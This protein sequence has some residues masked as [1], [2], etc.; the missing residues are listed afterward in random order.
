MKIARREFLY[1]AAGAAVLPGLAV[2]LSALPQPAPNA[3]N[4]AEPTASERS[5]MSSLARAFMEQ[6]DVPGLSVAVGRA[7]TLVYEDA[8][9]FADR[10]KRE[11][12]SPMHLFRIASV[13]KPITSVA[14]F[15]LIE[16][17][18]IRLTD[19]IFGPDAI[20]GSD[21]EMP[22]YR[23]DRPRVDDI[24]VEHLLTHTAG[25]WRNSAD[26]PMFMNL[27]MNHSQLIQWT[28]RNRPL[29]HSPGQNFAY[30]NFGY[31]VLGRV[32]EKVTGQPYAA[33][34]RNS[35]LKR[36]GVNDMTIAGNTLAQRLPEEV[37]YYGQGTDNP[38]GM[39]AARLDSCGGWIA[40]PADLVQFLMHVSGFATPP[41]ILK[42][43]TIAIMTTPSDVNDFYA[44]GWFVN[45]ANNWS[46]G[47]SLPG[48]TTTAARTHSGFC[49]AA[50][51]NTR[52]LNSPLQAG[53]DRLVWNMVGEVKSWQVNDETKVVPGGIFAC[54][55]EPDLKSEDAS[56]PTPIMFTNRTPHNVSLFWL[57]YR[58]ERVAY[59]TL[60]SGEAYTQETYIS[61]PWVIVDSHGACLQIVLPGNTTRTVAIE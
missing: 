48:T 12:V 39:N 43:Q 56:F 37:K 36:C 61:H 14:I 8:F 21:Y 50:F 38:Y 51:A 3:D 2:P 13:S 33:Y 6:Y 4:T 49:W 22:P 28:L 26:D 52:R 24:T 32:I 53:L 18:R 54:A 7:G 25:A 40:R 9:G 15:S 60:R 46:H 41:N 35:V 47:G 59:K 19:R 58:G 45:K 44:K 23:L 1:L 27:E 34:V 11:A 42:P 5:S 31:C 20:T 17:G 30:S 29:D 16:E 57:D 10:E 55:R